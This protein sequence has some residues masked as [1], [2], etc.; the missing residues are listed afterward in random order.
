MEKDPAKEYANARDLTEDLSRIQAGTISGQAGDRSGDRSKEGH[1]WLYAVALIVLSAIL[2]VVL[3]KNGLKPP[4]NVSAPQTL[5]I[6]YSC[7]PTCIARSEHPHVNNGDNVVLSATNMDVDISF[8]GG[9]PFKSGDKNIHIAQGN[10]KSE[11]IAGTSGTE[12]FYTLACSSCSTPAVSP[13]V[14][15]D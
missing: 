10:T 8:T 15:I 3:Q 14:I 4:P 9:S 6:V 5:Q 11:L 13:S 2:A 7:G 1:T 12:Y